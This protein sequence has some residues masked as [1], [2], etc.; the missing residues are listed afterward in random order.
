MFQL[1]SFSG[2]AFFAK[3]ELR[4]LAQEL[5]SRFGTEDAMHHMVLPP[6]VRPA[7]LQQYAITHN[8]LFMLIVAHVFLP[9]LENLGILG[10][11][12]EA[13]HLN[14]QQDEV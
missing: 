11:R 7:F 2:A 13:G 9:V 3:V 6:A 12:L 10:M 1:F 8:A 14:I 4:I 5:R